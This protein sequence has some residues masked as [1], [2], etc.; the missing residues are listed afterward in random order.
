MSNTPEPRPP[1]ATHATWSHGEDTPSHES[2]FVQPKT[3]L[4]LEP[5][6][7]EPKPLTP[8]DKEQMHGLVSRPT[9]EI[10]RDKVAG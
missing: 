4:R 8:L 3:Y 7:M 5:R 10:C 6:V 1:A 9:V 2:P